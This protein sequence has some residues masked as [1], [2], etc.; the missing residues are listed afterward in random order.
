MKRTQEDIGIAVL[1]VQFGDRTVETTLARKGER[2]AMHES[3][4]FLAIP[5]HHGCPLPTRMI[6]S[7]TSLL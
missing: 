1:I 4:P 5:L 3:F 6:N 7:D 2:V